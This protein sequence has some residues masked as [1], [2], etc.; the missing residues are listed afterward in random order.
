VQAMRA[1]LEAAAE[2]QDE[3]AA[4]KK[5][6]QSVSANDIATTTYGHGHGNFGGGFAGRI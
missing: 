5:L 1:A 4:C 3:V 6:F 2:Y